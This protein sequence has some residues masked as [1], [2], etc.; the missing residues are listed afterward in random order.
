[1]AGPTLQD[2]IM[3]LQSNYDYVTGAISYRNVGE[4]LGGV[5]GGVLVDKLGRFCFLI[6]GISLTAMGLTSVLLPFVNDLRLLG[7]QYFLLGTL[8]GMIN[9]GKY[10]YT[11]S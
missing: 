8:L 2:F 9:I 5:I 1:M 6:I 10:T 3:K 7:F 4:F 11:C